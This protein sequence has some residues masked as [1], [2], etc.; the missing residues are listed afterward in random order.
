ME[1]NDDCSIQIRGLSIHVEMEGEPHL[2][3]IIFLHGFTGSTAT[4]REVREQFRGSYRT[5][6]IDLTGHGKTTI[7][8]NP[9]RYSMEEQIEDLNELIEQL[10]IQSF[11]L[12]GYSMG[13]RIAL[14]YTIKYPEHVR[15]LILESASPGLKEEL[16]REQRRNADALL[17]KKITE[18]GITSFVDKWENIPLF[19]SQKSLS[20]KKRQDVRTE[21]LQQSEIGLANSLLGIGTGSQKSYWDELE[22]LNTAVYL[23]TGEFDAKFVAIAREMK[24]LVE[25]CRHSIVPEVGHAIHVENPSI[26]A[27]M[28][29]E[30]LHQL[31]EEENDTSMGNNPY[32]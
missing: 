10:S 22:T 31:K 17:A 30:Y 25:K 8:E 20:E 27:T 7:P 6:S 12:V 4:W 1:M 3:T 2:P 13:G 9:E 16:E 11:Y 28:I 26:F 32:I 14:G 19:E 5:V 24:N 18:N 29:K 21:R 23:I 15:A